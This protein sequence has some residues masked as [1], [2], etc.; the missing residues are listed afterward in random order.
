MARAENYY[1][2]LGVS[3]KAT[4]KEIKLAF[5]RLARQYHPDLNPNDPVSAEK[6]K[7]ISQAY[8]ILSDTTKRRRYDRRIPVNGR[9]KTAKKRTTPSQP[10]RK[11]T[12]PQTAQEF[13]NRGTLRTQTKDYQR[14][15]E[16]YTQAIRLD[17]KFIDAYLKR[18]E[19]RYK[20]GNNQ[21]VLDD[22][23]QIFSIDSKVAK[24]HYYQGRARYSLGYT[25]PAIESYS[26]AIAQDNHYPQ[27]YYYRGIAYKDLQVAD[28]AIQDLNQA[29][30]LFRT[31]KNYEA[32]RRSLKVIN[33][34]TKNKNIF[35]WMDSLIQ[36]SLVTM[37][38]SFFNPGGGLL[39]AFSR[40][41]SRQANQVGTTY[42]LFSALCFV[43]TYFMTGIPIEL[44][45]WQIFLIGM[46][47]FVSFVVSGSM[48]RYLLHRR[49]HFSI[50]V[51]IAGTA[52]VPL[53][54]TSILVG[55]ISFTAFSLIIPIILWGFSYTVLTLYTGYSQLLNITEAKSAIIVALML[56]ANSFV[57]FSLITKFIT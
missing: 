41:T 28:S 11:M 54:L 26:L 27:A 12:H 45:V 4:I 15:I 13:Y 51:F 50:D 1:S 55:F 14:A 57:C 22:C 43:C 6:F 37:S 56:V 16:D 48:M 40:L 25:E 19:M 44:G 29:A 23:Y 35:G 46:I 10:R 8:D 30:E 32:Y 34:I 3:Q 38:L 24:A 52:I 5:R 53:A 49:G 20:L 39:P 7:Q 9:E 18:C 17:P 42:G 36:N 2:T 47:P 31:R 21:G 33:E